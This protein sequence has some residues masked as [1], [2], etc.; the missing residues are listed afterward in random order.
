MSLVSYDSYP[1]VIFDSVELTLLGLLA[2]TLVVAFI[3]AVMESYADSPKVVDSATQT[4]VPPSDV[5]VSYTGQAKTPVG[6]PLDA[7]ILRVLADAPVPIYAKDIAKA[8]GGI[9]KSDVNKR[10]FS[11]LR[12]KEVT[13]YRTYAAP[14]WCV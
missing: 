10:L 7:D 12:R 14:L 13:Q 3:V 4:F 9:N 11:L 5:L 8:L 1:P 6:N 2:L